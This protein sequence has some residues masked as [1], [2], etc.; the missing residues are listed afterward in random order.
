ML[1][2]KPATDEHKAQFQAM[3]QQTM[4][5]EASQRR[6]L[7]PSAQ[8]ASPISRAMSQIKSWLT[9]TGRTSKG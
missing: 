5:H 9:P 1:Q 3:I 8:P 4:E 7:M 6:S 2:L